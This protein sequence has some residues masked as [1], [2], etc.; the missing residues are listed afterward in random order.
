MIHVHGSLVE[1][2]HD[3]DPHRVTMTDVHR[4]Y[5]IDHAF[6]SLMPLLLPTIE[7]LPYPCIASFISELPNPIKA[8]LDF[9]ARF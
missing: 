4:K 5:A 8:K 7:F 9:S 3:L 2:L 6:H 1:F